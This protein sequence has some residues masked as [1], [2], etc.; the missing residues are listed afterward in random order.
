MS[1]IDNVGMSAFDPCLLKQMG[2]LL[3]ASDGLT[4]RNRLADA[5]RMMSDILDA[6]VP[7]A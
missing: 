4:G 5:L 6:T 7:A 1:E 3:R 2:A